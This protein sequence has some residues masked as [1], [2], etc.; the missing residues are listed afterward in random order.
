MSYLK[1][2]DKAPNFTLINDQNEPVELFEQLKKHRV[3]LYFYPKA[4]TPGCTVQAQ[5][6]RDTKETLALQ[7]VVVL[8][9]SIDAPTR[10]AKFKERDQLNFHLLSDEDHATADLYGAWGPKK[11]M[12]RAYDGI[13]R[14]SYLIEQDGTIGQVFDKFKTKEHHNVVIDALNAMAHK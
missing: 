10:L 3:L 14:V 12:G 8:G 7:N 9:V 5:N 1:V 6:L 4:M 13:Y 2:G 11:F